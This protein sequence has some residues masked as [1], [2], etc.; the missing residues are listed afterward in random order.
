MDPT[1]YRLLASQDLCEINGPLGVHVPMGLQIGGH[2]ESP[3]RRDIQSI[4][5]SIGKTSFGSYRSAEDSSGRV[6]GGSS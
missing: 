4:E 3:A 2:H 5:A 1:G 6:V